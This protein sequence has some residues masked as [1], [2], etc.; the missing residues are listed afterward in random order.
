MSIVEDRMKWTSSLICGSIKS[1]H[2]NEDGKKVTNGDMVGWNLLTSSFLAKDHEVF[3]VLTGEKS[4]IIVVDFDYE[5][6]YHFLTETLKCFRARDYPTVKTKKGYHVYFE[7]TD[8]LLQPDK[9]KLNVD[10]QGNN[11]RVYYA[12][13]K[14]KIKDNDYFEYTWKVKESLKPI[15]DTLLNYINSLSKTKSQPKIA[16]KSEN[17]TN[18]TDAIKEIKA[19]C[20]LIDIKYINDRESW[21]KIVFALKR[22]GVDE[23]YAR[24]WSLTDDHEIN[25]EQWNKTWNSEDDRDEGVTL[26]TI[27]HYAKLS[28]PDAYKELNIR[29]DTCSFPIDNATERLFAVLFDALAGEHI[30]YCETDK[31]FYCW[32]K[33]NWRLEDKEG[34]YIRTLVS[35]ILPNHFKNMIFDVEKRIALALDE[36]ALRIHKEK[37]NALQK[38]V[39]KL[40]TTSWLNNIWKELQ[41]IVVCRCKKVEFDTNPQVIGFKNLKYNFNSKKWSDIEYNDFISMSTG[42]DWVEPTQ[43]QSETIKKLFEE[44]F[45]NKEIRRSYLSILYNCCIGGKKD[46][47]VIANGGGANGKGLINELTKILLGDYAYDAPVSLLTR[48]FRG[49]ANPELA[50]IHKKRFVLYKEPDATEKLFLGNIKTL[51]DNDTL[52]ARQLYKGNCNVTLYATMIME[53]NI[54]LK[55]SGKPTNAEMRRF[56]DI[57]FESTFTDNKNNLKDTTL[58]NIYPMNPYYKSLEFQRE[59]VCALFKYIIDNADREI[60]NPECVR[61]RTRCY[62]EGEDTFSNWFDENYEITGDKDDVLKLKTMFESYKGSDDYRNMRKDERPNLHRFKMMSVLTDN[63]LSSRFKESY[64]YTLNGTRKLQRSVLLGIKRIKPELEEELEDL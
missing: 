56:M 50:N 13:T 20:D 59:H 4:N 48:E 42:N 8:K 46:K 2:L 9:K 26:G 30:V 24:K 19:Y 40:T 15:P 58:I 16:S 3:F 54:R 38:L 11:K 63:K 5:T 61:E 14:Y 49:G 23:E 64:E 35:D 1:M 21:L 60:Y 31:E 34:R 37:K 18:D 29:N 52:P 41:S 62:I 22:C 32:F 45:P 53:T 12:G 39:K 25:D 17:T 47:F 10:I 55:F 6:E 7:Y 43:E 44:I 27:K 28:K 51:V 36:C 57:L 33:N